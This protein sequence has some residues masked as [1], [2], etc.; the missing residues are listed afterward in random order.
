[1]LPDLLGPLRGRLDAL[2]VSFRWLMLSDGLT[3]LA[4][5]VGQV[6]LPWWIA[7]EGGAHDLAAYTVATSCFSIVAMPL[8][9]PLGDRV[10]KRRLIQGALVTFAV[11]SI[12]FAL[13]A[14]VGR[15]ALPALI[16]LG[17]LPVLAMAAQLPAVSSFVTE[18][19]APQGLSRALAL[20]QGAQATGRMVGPAIG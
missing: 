18:L 8:M 11:A 4:L 5:M 7:G 17:A 6:A 10:P 14:S 13:L 2:G 1:M 15:Y 19:V 3:L 9:S 12:A 16:V 20:Q